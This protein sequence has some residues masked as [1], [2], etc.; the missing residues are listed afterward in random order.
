V[1]IAFVANPA[2]GHVLPLL[3]LAIAARDAGHEVVVVAGASCTKAIAG[4]GL[5]HVS[6]PTPD[7][8]S[9]FARIPGRDG[10]SGRRLAV[11]TWRH[12]FAG[13][14]ATELATSVLDLA[15]DWRPDLVVHEDSEQG[16]WIA[17]E[18]LGIP[19][20]TLQATA[21]RGTMQRLA[22]EPLNR[23][24][25]AHGLPP[26]PELARQHARGFLTTRPPSLHDP[27][28]PM[29]ASARPLRPVAAD[30]ALADAPGWIDNPRAARRVCV[31]MGTMPLATEAVL[32]WIAAAFEGFDGEVVVTTGPSTDPALLGSPPEN[33]RVVPYVPMSRLLP[34]CAAVVFHAG[35]GTMLAALAAGVPMV[36]VP[37]AADQPT[38]AERCEAAGVG[39][40]VRRD[41]RDAA[42]VRD[43]VD[44]VL[45]DE[46][47]AAAAR[48][49]RLEIEAMPPPDA[50]VRQLEVVVGS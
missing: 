14:L 3:P 27:S 42:A 21:W 32:P 1:R 37:V 30:E 10:L 39:V 24:R 43:A 40:V 47:Y 13:I 4:A 22:R 17:A 34:T 26:D 50:V 9:A 41:A 6:S 11:A 19:A 28:D 18:R 29:P 36:L 2:L 35:S 49:V 46:R 33:A 12:V 44:R 20:I 38:N 15:K 48:R 45:G 5:R 23:L 31:T 25:A 8:A 7:L 16:S